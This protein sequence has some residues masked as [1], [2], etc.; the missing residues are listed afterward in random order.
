[1]KM[2]ISF[3]SLRKNENENRLDARKFQISNEDFVYFYNRQKI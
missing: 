3:N 1:M 2:F